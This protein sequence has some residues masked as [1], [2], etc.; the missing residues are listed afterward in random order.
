MRA[1]PALFCCAELRPSPMWSPS[2]R[3]AG[4]FLRSL[5]VATAGSQWCFS[6]KLL[7]ARWIRVS[8]ALCERVCWRHRACNEWRGL[9]ANAGVFFVVFFFFFFSFRP[10]PPGFRQRFGSLL[11][12]H[13]LRH[14]CDEQLAS[15]VVFSFLRPLRFRAQCRTGALSFASDFF[16]FFFFSA[17]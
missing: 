15:C 17:C 4:D 10:A 8:V 9:P 11:L 2:N 7:R 1:V 13:F 3:R 5:S 6:L 16:A 14:E 12:R